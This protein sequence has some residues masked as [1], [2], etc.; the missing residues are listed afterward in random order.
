[1]SGNPL[2]LL[3]GV[4]VANV[5]AELFAESIRAQ[6]GRAAQVDWKPPAGG[7][8]QTAGIIERMSACDEANERAAERLQAARPTWID[9]ATA[10]DVIPGMQDRMILHSGPP[11]AWE[12]MSG[13]MRGAVVG[14]ILLEGWAK[15][16][17]EAERLGA[18]GE[19]S[20][21][22]C[23]HHSSVGPMAGVTSPSMPVNV[24]ENQAPP[25]LGGGNRAYCNLNEGL[26]KVLR[27]GAYSPEVLDRLRWMREEL[28]PAIR[29]TIRAMGGLDI[30][31]LIARAIHMGDEVHNRNL[32]ATAT[33]IRMTMPHLADAVGDGKLVARAARFISGNDHFFL[34]YGMPSAKASLE[35]MRGVENCSLVYTMARNGTDFGIRVSGLGERWFT[36]PAKMPIG[37]FFPGFRQ[38]DANPDIGD[39]AI[40]ETLG[41]GGFVMGAA[42]AIVQ[43]VGGTPAEALRATNEMYGIT[44][45]RSRDYTLPVLEFAGAP[46]AIDVRKVVET[47]VLP[48]INTGIAHRQAGIGQIGAGILRAPEAPFRE[49]LLALAEKMG[50]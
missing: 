4:R 45:T 46:M 6:G 23:H 19:I 37:L 15:D 2:S 32:A 7:D 27:Y 48:I 50:V 17:R 34:N 29:A 11:I 33:F 24:I 39:S 49:A 18:N 14:A 25:E 22:P 10:K 5:G 42:P 16:E 43:F 9:V 20:F 28:G 35:A 38:E 47:N 21:E 44:W 12:R 26:G 41:L 36:A 30:K 3:E 8:R 13:P 31:N 1:M 40:M